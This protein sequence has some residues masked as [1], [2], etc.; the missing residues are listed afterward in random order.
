MKKTFP[1]KKQNGKKNQRKRRKEKYNTLENDTK[2]LK[3]KIEEENITIVIEEEEDIAPDGNGIIESQVV[4]DPLQEINRQK[5]EEEER[6]K[7]K[8]L[9]AATMGLRRMGKSKTNDLHLLSQHEMTPMDSPN[10]QYRETTI[11]AFIRNLKYCLSNYFC[12]CCCSSQPE[13]EFSNILQVDLM[14]DDDMTD[15]D[16]P[17]T[18]HPMEHADI[19]SSQLEMNEQDIYYAAEQSKKKNKEQWIFT[20]GEEK[21]DLSPPPQHYLTPLEKEKRRELL[22]SGGYLGKIVGEQNKKKKTLILD[23]DETLVHSS[24]EESVSYDIDLEIQV[25]PGHLATVYV[26]KRPHVDEFLEKVGKLFEVVIF[27]A[28]LPKYANPLIDQLDKTNTVK[29]RLFREHCIMH[30]SYFIKDLTLLGRKLSNTI[31]VDN[32]PICY[33]FQP[34]NAVPVSSWFVNPD[35][36]QLRTVMPWLEKLAEAEQIYPIIEA[37]KK[38]MGQRL[39]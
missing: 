31:I 26:K 39:W 18:E 36:D 12:C 11:Q 6:K 27:T 16:D 5:E 24:F 23:L 30:G 7:R 9:K 38:N 14:K 20:V 34:Q 28:S 21:V 22:M 1:G 29:K 17:T 37:Y 35:D 25:S 33:Q 8:S 3:E 19:I 10:Y 13:A 2:N 4:M 15:T 32:S